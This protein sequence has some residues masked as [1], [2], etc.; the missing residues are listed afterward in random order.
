MG[1]GAQVGSGEGLEQA[2]NVITHKP[3]LQGSHGHEKP[4][5][6]MEC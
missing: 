4:G 5:K 3:K 2:V 1:E 6:V